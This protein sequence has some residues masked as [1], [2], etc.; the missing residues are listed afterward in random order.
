MSPGWGRRFEMAV[1]VGTLPQCR[2]G[3]L[4]KSTGSVVVSGAISRIV[5]AGGNLD[6]TIPMVSVI[7]ATA[8]MAFYACA[9]I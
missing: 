2:G 6:Q 1:D 3:A 7:G 9:T 5:K 8:G 4:G